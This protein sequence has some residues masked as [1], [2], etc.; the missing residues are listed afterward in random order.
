M[1]AMHLSETSVDFQRTRR[2]YLWTHLLTVTLHYCRKNKNNSHWQGLFRALHG[3]EFLC[4][5]LNNN[6]NCP[7]TQLRD[8]TVGVTWGDRYQT[9]TE[10]RLQLW[11]QAVQNQERRRAYRYILSRLFLVS[12]VAVF[13]SARKLLNFFLL[14]TWMFFIY[15]YAP[16]YTHYCN[17]Y[18]RTEV[19]IPT[20]QKIK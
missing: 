18:D 11:R 14:R 16:H 7:T 8:V 2:R 9:V 20:S 15:V 6:C 19:I 1:E 12:S 3:Q 10:T 5:E 4:E 17:P 13:V